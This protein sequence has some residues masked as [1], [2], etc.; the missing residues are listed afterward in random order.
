MPFRNRSEA[1][2]RLAVALAGYKVEKRADSRCHGLRGRG[3]LRAFVSA[4]AKR[5]Q[6]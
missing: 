2:R 1:G 3:A 4:Y 6:R 5:C